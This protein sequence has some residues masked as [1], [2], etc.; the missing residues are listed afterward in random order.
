MKSE[1]SK[2]TDTSNNNDIHINKNKMETQ[3]E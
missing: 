1:N 2:H 3:I